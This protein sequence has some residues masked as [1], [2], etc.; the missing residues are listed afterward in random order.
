MLQRHPL[1]LKNRIAPEIPHA[2]I[3]DFKWVKRLG[4]R[5]Y[6]Y[7]LLKASLERGWLAGVVRTKVRIVRHPLLWYMGR[8]LWRGPPFCV[9]TDIEIEL[10]LYSEGWFCWFHLAI[11]FGI[12]QRNYRLAFWI[13]MYC[14]HLAQ[15]Y[16]RSNKRHG[17]LAWLCL[18][19]IAYL[20]QPRSY[21]MVASVHLQLY[22]W[23][24][25]WLYCWALPLSSYIIPQAC[26]LL[27]CHNPPVPFS[28]KSKL[29]SWR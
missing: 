21:L 11:A 26:V 29:K 9:A 8:R 16:G 27:L 22:F 23:P 25:I 20:R 1:N 7:A 3:G 14:G 15:S 28:F 24:R 4:Y 6:V 17:L 2:S 13:R 5:I 18:C 12:G 19:C 10:R